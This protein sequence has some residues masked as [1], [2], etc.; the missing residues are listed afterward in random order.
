VATHGITLPT[1]VALYSAG[2]YGRGSRAW[3][4]LGL[5]VGGL[6]VAAA[7]DIPE[8]EADL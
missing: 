1:R 7:Y 4:G 5:I 2:A 3:L 8:D 6:T